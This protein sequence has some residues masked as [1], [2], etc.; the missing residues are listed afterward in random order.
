MKKIQIKFYIIRILIMI[1]SILLGLNIQN[2][3]KNI[4][5]FCKLHYQDKIFLKDFTGVFLMKGLLF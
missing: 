5:D 1:G 2:N 3:G 4:S